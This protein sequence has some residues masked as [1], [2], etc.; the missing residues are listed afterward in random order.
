MFNFVAVNFFTINSSSNLF[1]T[2]SYFLLSGLVY[3]NIMFHETFDVILFQP[4][5]PSIWKG[6]GISGRRGFQETAY[7]TW[8][9]LMPCAANNSRIIFDR[10]QS[11]RR[12][13][14]RR[15]FRGRCGVF[16]HIIHGMCGRRRQEMRG[17]LPKTWRLSVLLHSHFFHALENFQSLD[18]RPRDRTVFVDHVEY[19]MRAREG[20]I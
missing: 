15:I 9:I 4:T 7:K 8:P 11:R 14:V 17:A 12:R 1:A 10:A 3:R 2:L 6:K 18:R 16:S 5:I 20:N 19:V 13:Y